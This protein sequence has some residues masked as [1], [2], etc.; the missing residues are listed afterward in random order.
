M[1]YEPK[2]SNR[3]IGRWRNSTA[4]VGG[5]EIISNIDGK[6]LACCRIYKTGKSFRAIAWLRDRTKTFFQR[7]ISAAAGSDCEAIIAAFAD[8][9]VPIPET[10]SFYTAALHVR[11]VLAEAFDLNPFFVEF[12]A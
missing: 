9:N 1:S 5:F 6:T 3:A 2:N 11:N 4:F 7:G 10:E 12:G 8:A